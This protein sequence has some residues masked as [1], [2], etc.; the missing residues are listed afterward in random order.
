MALTTSLSA[1]L[2]ATY[3]KRLLTRAVARMVHGKWATPV[4]LS[5]SNQ[6]EARK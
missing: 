6:W 4:T 1:E 2:K 5:K 3:E